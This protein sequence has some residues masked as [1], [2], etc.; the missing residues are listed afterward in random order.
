MANHEEERGGEEGVRDGRE[1][2]SCV[3]P[4]LV[5]ETH[6]WYNMNYARLGNGTDGVEVLAP[7][8]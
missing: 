3:V 4:G 5:L 2:G 8:K 7:S 6:F 1:S